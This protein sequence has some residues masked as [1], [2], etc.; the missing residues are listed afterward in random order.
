M[1]WKPHVTVAAVAVQD[2]RYL[3]VE[4]EVAGRHVLNQPAGHLEPGETLLEAVIREAREETTR[5]FTP[6]AVLG[7]YR[8]ANPKSQQTFLRVCFAGE[9]SEPVPGRPLDPAIRTTVWLHPDALHQDPGRLRSPM[10]LQGI[11]DHRAGSRFP[12]ELLRD[13]D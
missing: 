5:D 12:L 6:H 13:L 2:G 1:V 11:E 4:E 10:V 3:L 9:V 8:W 7:V